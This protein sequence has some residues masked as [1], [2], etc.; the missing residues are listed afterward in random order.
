MNRNLPD[1]APVDII[2][3]VY[4]GL[5]QTRRCLESVLA[6]QQATSFELVLI[7]DCSPD[8]ELRAYLASLQD[9]PRVTLLVNERNLGFVATVNRAWP[10]TDRDVALLNSDT[11]V[12]NGWLIDYGDALQPGGHRDGDFPILQRFVLSS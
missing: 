6:A 11:E 12:A 7:D 2:V 10:C 5:E 1:F 9:R 3:P 4:R 8:P